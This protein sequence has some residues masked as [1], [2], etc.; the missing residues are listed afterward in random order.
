MLTACYEEI[1][2]LWKAGKFFGA[3]CYFCEWMVEALL[4]QE[5]TE[6]F[7]KNLLKFWELVEVECEENPAVMFNLYEMVKKARNWDD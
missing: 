1:M 2:E 7:N 6:S 4:N 3:I 5:K